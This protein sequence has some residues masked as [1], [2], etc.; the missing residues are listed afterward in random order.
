MVDFCLLNTKEVSKIPWLYQKPVSA[1]EPVRWLRSFCLKVCRYLQ[2]LNSAPSSL[3]ISRPQFSS[4]WFHKAFLQWEQLRQAKEFQ[5][6]RWFRWT[7]KSAKNIKSF[8]NYQI[9]PPKLSSS[10]WRRTVCLRMQVWALQL[11]S[12][13]EVVSA[14]KG[15][16][17]K[18]NKSISWILFSLT[19]NDQYLEGTFLM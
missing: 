13:R 4:R 14:L 5:M 10:W 8:I 6:S 1:A 3:K 19:S 2:F 7:V 11:R 15:L 18:I 9:L 16:N 17:E 12:C